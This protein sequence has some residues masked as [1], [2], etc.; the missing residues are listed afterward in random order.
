MQGYLAWLAVRQFIL[1]LDRKMPYNQGPA[2]RI[3]LQL[4]ATLIIGLF[5]ISILTEAVSWIARGH[6]APLNFYTLDLVIISI[7]F[8]VI[9]GI[10]IGLYYYHEWQRLE[11]SRKE[12]PRPQADGMV[13]RLGKQDI[14]L[15]YEDLSGFYVEGDYVIACHTG[16]KKYY[17]DPS[18]DKIEKELPPDV[19]FRLNRQY[20]VNRLLVSG[21]KRIENGKILVLLHPQEYFP[22]EIPVSRTKAPAFKSW[23]RPA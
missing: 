19:F 20:L 2:R 9:N 12:M 7:W 4:F 22:P 14:R 21:F 15:R 13:I 6:A 5:V 10:Y 8:F 3:V 16:G 11:A 1:Y 23:F 18:L 17:V